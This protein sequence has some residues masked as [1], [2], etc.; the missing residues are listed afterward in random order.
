MENNRR[1]SNT[2]HTKSKKK[3]FK[4]LILLKNY[5]LQVI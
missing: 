2:N 1:E 4:L 5:I 3:D